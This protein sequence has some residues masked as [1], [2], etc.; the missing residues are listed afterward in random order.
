M[1][2]WDNVKPIGFKTKEVIGDGFAFNKDFI[3]VFTEIGK[4]LR[5]QVAG[6]EGHCKDV[7]PRGVCFG[8]HSRFT[9]RSW[10]KAMKSVMAAAWTKAVVGFVVTNS[11]FLL[12]MCLPCFYLLFFISYLPKGE[13]ALLLMFTLLLPC[14]SHVFALRLTHSPIYLN[15]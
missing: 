11:S 3:H 2:I 14:V 6:I 7:I 15:Q 8:M 13:H 1:V 10:L 5:P 12:N 4:R 9:Q